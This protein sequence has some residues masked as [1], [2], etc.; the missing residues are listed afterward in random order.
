[1]EIVNLCVF[2]YVLYN[3]GIHVPLS[4]SLSLYTVQCVH[5]HTTKL[6]KR[7]LTKNICMTSFN[8]HSDADIDVARE[9]GGREKSTASI[10]FSVL[11]S[12]H[13]YFFMLRENSQREK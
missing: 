2:V 13:T 5:T 6:L 7:A 9:G 1:M 3:C 8:A 4:L 11:L 12:V 10:I